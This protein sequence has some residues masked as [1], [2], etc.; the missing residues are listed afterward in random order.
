MDPLTLEATIT[1]EGDLAAL[2]SGNDRETDKTT[3]HWEGRTGEPITL[4]WPTPRHVE[5][6][7]LIFDSDLN[8]PK[9]MPCRYPLAG[10]NHAMPAS[11][12]KAF[13]LEGQ[14]A[15]GEWETLHREEENTR[16]LSVHPVRRS[17]R[18]LRWT[19]Q[20]TWGAP[21]VKLFS[22]EATAKSLPLSAQP[23]EGMNWNEVTATLDPSD[24]LAPDHGLEA[25]R[26]GHSR[27]GA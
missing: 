14:G 5:C 6:V 25:A 4:A 10:E 19:A 13:T 20:S 17:L 12:V 9:M 21:M 26:K 3:H 7:R 1:G 24:L 11:L 15:S 18:A 23:A 27:V 16:R 2:L 8:N 22:I